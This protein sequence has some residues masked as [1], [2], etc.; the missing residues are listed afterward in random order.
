MA[1]T[2]LI[3]DTVHQGLRLLFEKTGY[4]FEVRN[5]GDH[6]LGLW[7][8]PFRKTPSAM[9]RRFVFVPGFGDTPLSWLPVFAPLV[10][11]LRHQYDEIVLLDLPGFGGMLSSETPFESMASLEALVFH[12]LDS[13]RPHTLMGHSL[14]GWI[15]GRYAVER[16][17]SLQPKKLIIADPSG[18]FGGEESLQEFGRRFDEILEG[19][20]AKLRPHVFG[21]EPIWFRFLANEFSHFVQVPEVTAFI[22]SIDRSYLLDDRLDQI[23]ASV[24]L[25]WGDRD[26]LTPSAWGDLWLRGLTRTD[27]PAKLIWIKGS[28]HSP[29]IEKT[30]SVITVLTQEL[31]GKAPLHL[32]PQPLYKVHRLPG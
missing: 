10:P 20:F 31:L 1:R 3:L 6:K 27:S 28:G 5:R 8:Y 25:L 16:D 22:R 14:G 23:R 7:R 4:E 24:T 18:V 11:V 26:T 32:I 2:R 19:G 21:K 9:P 30:A 29:Q 12:T 15:S 17:P 13:L